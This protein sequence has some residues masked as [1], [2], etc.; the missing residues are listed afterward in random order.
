MSSQLVNIENFESAETA[1]MFAAL[2]HDSGGVNTWSHNR[3]PAAIEHQ[4]VIRLNRDTL[5][6]FAVVDIS[7]GA[8]VTVP[9]GDGRYLSVMVVNQDQYINK[10]IH[11]PGEHALTLDDFETP[12]VPVAVRVLVDPAD[13]ADVAAVN[14]LQDKFGLQARSD[15]PFVSPDYDE[16]S[17]AATRQALLELARGVGGIDRTFGRKEEVDPVRHLIG[18]AAGWG[19]LPEHE[20]Y[21]VNVDPGLPVAKYQPTVKDVPV[22]AFLVD[23][24]LQRRRV[25]RAERAQRVHRQQH[26]GDANDDGSVTVHFGGCG[27]GRPNCLPLMDG[28]NYIVRLH[29]PRPEVLDG[30]WAFPSVETA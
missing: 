1:R 29:R 4:T 27:D 16:A 22:D 25:L 28:W 2:Q 30:S 7:K 23:F 26:H 15:Q 13:P 5:Y 17:Q 20:A 24:A 18:T 10:V 21:Y 9:D 11:E 3:E 19:G 12:Y 6:S 14:A 8:T